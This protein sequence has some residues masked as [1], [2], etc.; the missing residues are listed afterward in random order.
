MKN[1]TRRITLGLATV[2]LGAFAVTALSAPTVAN[3]GLIDGSLNNLQAADHSN[4]L[5][6]MV[7]STL[8]VAGNLTNSRNKA[9]ND[10]SGS[11]GRR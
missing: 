11:D 6:A 4:I 8:D 2:A 10:A 1:L 5:G 3:A 9:N 7:G